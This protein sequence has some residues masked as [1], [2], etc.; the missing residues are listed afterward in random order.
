MKTKRSTFLRVIRWLCVLVASLVILLGLALFFLTLRPGEKI[1]KRTAEKQLKSVFKQEVHIGELETNLL[2]RFQIRDARIY[3]LLP[4]IE[5]RPLL[6]LK[7]AKVEYRLADLLRR[8]LSIR[9][10]ELDGLKLTVQR[11]SLGALNIPTS[12]PS[13]KP[14][15][16]QKVPS[17]H[18]L[19][20]QLSI[21]NS[22]CQYRDAQVPMAGLLQDL[23][24]TA[25]NVAEDTYRYH[26]RVD[27]IAV[28]YQRASLAL[29]DVKMRGVWHPQ[30]WQ[31]VSLSM[32]LPD[33]ALSGQA[34]VLQ[35]GDK[36]SITG[37]FQLQGNPGLLW[38]QVGP[39]F[40]AE[41]PLLDGHLNLIAA[42]E[43]A[44]PKPRIQAHLE[45]TDFQGASI[46]LPRGSVAARWESGTTTLE[47]L[48]L[49][50][51]GGNISG[52]GSFIAD[53]LNTFD[54]SL[55]VQA[56]DIAQTWQMLYQ[57]AAPYQGRISGQVSLTGTGRQPKD[58][59][60]AANIQLQ[61]VQY[62]SQPIPDFAARLSYEGGTARLSL[63]HRD[64]RIS[65]QARLED[66]R[67][68]GSF[69]LDIADLEPLAALANVQELTGTMEIQGDLS[70]TLRS[71]QVAMNLSGRNI[72]YQ[73]FPVDS[74]AGSM[75]YQD[76]Q[77][78]LSDMFCRG[79]LAITDT[80][81][82]PFHLKGIL[83]EI[84][85]EAR[86]SGPANDPL[87]HLYVNLHQVSYGD[88]RIDQGHLQIGL[89]NRQVDLTHLNVR[90]DSLLVSA[91]G[92]A[93]IDSRRATCQ[94]NLFQILTDQDSTAIGPPTLPE[95]F[96]ESSEDLF[97][98]G[99]ITGA[100]DFSKKEAPTLQLNGELFD[101]GKLAQALPRPVEITGA[102]KF[103]L[104]TQGDLDNPNAE[105]S[106]RCY[107]MGHGS[108]Q[109]DS[110]RGYL[111]FA[112][113]Q[114][115]LKSLDLFEQDHHSL[116]TAL[117]EVTVGE[118]GR[119][120][121]SDQSTFRGQVQGQELDLGIVQSFLPSEMQIAGL[122]SYDLSWQGTLANPHPFGTI[123]I[124]KG[125]FRG[126]PSA[127][128]IEQIDLAL[129][130]QDSVLTIDQL[131]A[132]FRQTPLQ[133]RGQIITF[134]FQHFE[135]QLELSV[136]NYGVIASQG[137]VTPDSL[138]L[139]ANIRKMDLSLL[140]PFFTDVQNLSGTLNTE[141]L[142]TGSPQDPQ[143]K[144][145]LMIRHLVLQPQGL[146]AP[147]TGGMVTAR[148]DRDTATID[149]LFIRLGEGTIFVAGH[150]A[151]S[152]GELTDIDLQTRVRGLNIN[153][154]KQIAVLIQS[155]DLDY[156]KVNGS[157]LLEGDVILGQTR[158]L[159]DFK[160]QSI[161]PF[162]KRV[163]RPEKEL[164]ALLQQTRLDLRL[165]ESENIW[166]DNNLARLRLHAELGIVGT[167]TQPNLSGRVS[168]EE[169]YILY[170]DRKFKIQK[171]I[172]DFAD[173]QR[174]NPII[175]LTAES[176]VSSYQEQEWQTYTIALSVQGPLD[177]VQ[178]ALTSEPPL[179]RPDIISLLT[180]GRTRGQ[181]SSREA[182]SN[183]L[184]ERAKDFS[185]RRITGYTE[186]KLGR[187][188]GLEQITIE[189]NLFR[190]DKTWGPRL[191][192]SKK[193]S[194]RMDVTYT[195]TVGYLNDYNIQLGYRLTPHFSLVSQTDQRGRSGLDLL[196]KLKFP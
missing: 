143:L 60:T 62:H 132:S 52:T 106:F 165:R 134:R 37:R 66:D 74:L 148:F 73:D 78:S 30:K 172:V 43:G 181:L 192:A 71:P 119:Y 108:A 6:N 51:L 163:N 100:V 68:A 154:P 193:I 50:V 32:N 39:L 10:L 176:S 112:D 126:N 54:L 28:K 98:L 45:L 167:A 12:E 90:R 21:E 25:E 120:S 79:R 183:A 93:D 152:R 145:Q 190:F 22:S 92:H 99:G 56:I 115:Q 77:I 83:G 164:P 151:H 142:L 80:L 15:T 179:D 121:L 171:G 88:Y 180:L 24:I 59:T 185:S 169:G 5:Q 138:Q 178:V 27:S 58:W 116:A 70:G 188:L 150:V 113:R 19:L 153:R 38:Q 122:C 75:R 82:T 84:S 67:L 168:V 81:Q 136:A 160:P 46:H 125:T 34:E 114:V 97:A 109:I 26:I 47:K 111:V 63:D 137:T 147:L 14:K 186:R 124:H 189:G 17:F 170:L 110:L 191:V 44:L 16:E 33:L 102:V 94:V 31:L 177:E 42:L 187:L 128:P 18:V 35:N 184:V 133:L 161:S 57:Q 29:H 130:L 149:S 146:D 95:G 156:R 127:P 155:I 173:P 65:A 158:F 131:T 162:A 53:S 11:D 48:Q 96:V 195:T 72:A 157:Y 64:S 40:A 141:I 144:G 76:D 2:S 13:G 196:Y 7:Y 117:I 101:L 91:A 166:V 182:G 89:K 49:N 175:D 85:Y 55:D 23:S 20:G 69:S 159:A 9:S 1:L 41:V 36:P 105:L 107:G 104:K 87:A 123:Q 129:S 103:D 139:E 140:Q 118:D 8:K 174:L 4:N 194:Q 3:S 86:A 135:A 61:R